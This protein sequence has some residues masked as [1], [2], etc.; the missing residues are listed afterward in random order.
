VLPQITEPWQ[1]DLRRFLAI[2]EPIIEVARNELAV[3][4]EAVLTNISGRSYSFAPHP[5]VLAQFAQTGLQQ[6]DGK[7]PRLIYLSRL[8]VPGRRT[9]ENEEAVAQ[10][11]GTH[12]F[13]IVD[14]GS[15]SIDQQVALFRSAD[16]I[17]AP[18][19]AALTNLVYAGDGRLGPKVIELVQES[20]LGRSFIKIAQAKP[21]NY[22]VI[23]NPD[24]RFH[25]YH[26]DR[27]WNCDLELLTQVLANVMA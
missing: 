8:G 9:M 22:S 2:S 20:Y 26:H 11:L 5:T 18:H 27:T 3:F 6:A 13:S 19:G 15:L 1:T 17:V 4:D 24:A 16:V 10:L 7:L 14:N 12:G 21:L 25:D 23:V